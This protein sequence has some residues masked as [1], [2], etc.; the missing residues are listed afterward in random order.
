MRIDCSES[1]NPEYC[2]YSCNSKLITRWESLKIFDI[3]DYITKNERF[4]DF[5]NRLTLFG[6]EVEI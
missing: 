6:S 4:K 2:T 5:R 1:N 3:Y